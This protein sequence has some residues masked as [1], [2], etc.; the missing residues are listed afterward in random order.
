MCVGFRPMIQSKLTVLNKAGLAVDDFSNTDSTILKA[1][2]FEC[3]CVLCV[4]MSNVDTILFYI[5]TSRKHVCVLCVN[6]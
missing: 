1:C 3:V 6:V 2:V 5:Y 4:C